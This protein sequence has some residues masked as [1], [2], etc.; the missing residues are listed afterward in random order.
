MN[1]IC[2][3]LRSVI[4]ENRNKTFHILIKRTISRISCILNW[5]HSTIFHAYDLQLIIVFPISLIKLNNK[6]IKKYIWT[7]FLTNVYLWTMSKFAKICKNVAV[8]YLN[9]C[10]YGLTKYIT[11]NVM[12]NFCD[13]YPLSKKQSLKGVTCYVRYLNWVCSVVENFFRIHL[14]HIKLLKDL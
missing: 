8:F 3:V 7:K 5:V 9:K 2:R 6:N 13:F 12:V 4:S 11:H 14:R 10:L 1:R